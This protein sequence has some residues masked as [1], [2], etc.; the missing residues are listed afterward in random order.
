LAR[1]RAI[2]ALHGDGALTQLPG[3]LVARYRG[4]ALEAAH[5]Y[6]R[7]LWAIVRPAFLGRD[8]CTPRIWS[9]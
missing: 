8:A 2:I 9:T 6:F 1:C 3:V 7:A 5:D 4:A